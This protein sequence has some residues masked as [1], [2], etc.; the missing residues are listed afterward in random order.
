MK[1]REKK[2]LWIYAPLSVQSHAVTAMFFQTIVI[3]ND[4]KKDN[5]QLWIY[6]NIINIGMK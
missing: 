3:Y 1:D 4:G 6:K 5:N 2:L